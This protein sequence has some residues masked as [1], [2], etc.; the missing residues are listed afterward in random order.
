MNVWIILYILATLFSF[1]YFLRVSARHPIDAPSW[2]SALSC[3]A[4]AVFWPIAW[5]LAAGIYYLE[6]HQ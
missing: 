6:T 3:L 1:L 5:V 4:M 2:L